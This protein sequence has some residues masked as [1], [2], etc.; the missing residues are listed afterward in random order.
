MKEDKSGIQVGKGRWADRGYYGERI[1]IDVAT[2]IINWI[3]ESLN[4]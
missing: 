3:V 1:M 4:C 2:V